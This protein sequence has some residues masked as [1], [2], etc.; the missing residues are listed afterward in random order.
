MV[1]SCLLAAAFLCLP[2]VAAGAEQKKVK[3]LKVL[4]VTGGSSHDYDSQKLILSKGIAARANVDWTIAHLGGKNRNRKIKLFMKTNWAAGYDVVVHNQCFGG[5]VDVPFVEG[6]ARVHAEGMPAVMIHCTPHSYRNAKTDAWRKVVGV[7]S[8]SHEK[9]RPL[10]V[11]NMAVDHPV[12]KG[13]PKTWNT[14]NG[15]LY[16]IDKL[17]PGVTPLGKAFGKDTQKDHVCIWTNTH[18]KMRV[19]GTTIGHHNE[20]MSQ[21]TYLDLV[22]RGLLWACGKLD[23]NGKPE[24]GYAKPPTKK[25]SGA[26]RQ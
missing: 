2:G 8:F 19:F 25:P 23:K 10:A 15:E 24:P 16:K 6:I 3:P 11:Q 20:T 7:S 12:M 5:V 13:F 21:K 9:H 26:A 4:M 22:T 1:A 18:G 17:W 14:P